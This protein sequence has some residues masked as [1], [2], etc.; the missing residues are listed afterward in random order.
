MRKDMFEIII[1]RPRYDWGRGRGA[2]KGRYATRMKADLE[3]SPLKEGIKYRGRTRDLNENL[4]PLRRFLERRVGRPWDAVW[5]EIRAS[6]SPKS[7]VQKHVF[8]HVLQYVERN[9][10]LIDGIPHAPAGNGPR[11]DDF[12]PLPGYGRWK[13]FYVC[14]RTGLLCDASQ[15]HRRRKKRAPRA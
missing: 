1:E 2:G 12:L 15:A 10:I 4:A 3:A 14:P 6:L 13:S 5:S 8:D 11:R 7:A 9:P